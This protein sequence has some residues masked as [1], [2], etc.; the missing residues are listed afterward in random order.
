[1][2]VYKYKCNTLIII[3]RDRLYSRMSTNG[4]IH[5]R[6]P[7]MRYHCKSYECKP[8]EKST[9]KYRQRTKTTIGISSVDTDVE[10][11]IKPSPPNGVIELFDENSGEFYLK[12]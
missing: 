6:F 11:D 2:A 5:P 3:K 1:M 8:P 7:E 4:A 12:L 10:V 9:A